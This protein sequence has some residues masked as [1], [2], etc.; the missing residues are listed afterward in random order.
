MKTSEKI[1]EKRLSGEQVLQKKIRE[2]DEMIKNM[3]WEQ[4]NKVMHKNYPTN[5]R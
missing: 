2:V 4:F 5:R 3:N 1:T